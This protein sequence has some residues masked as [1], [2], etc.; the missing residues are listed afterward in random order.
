M[1]WKFDERA[2]SASPLSQAFPGKSA[3][4]VQAAGTYVRIQTDAAA[5]HRAAG[6]EVREKESFS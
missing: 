3:K 6:L 5:N 2:A 1:P 4:P